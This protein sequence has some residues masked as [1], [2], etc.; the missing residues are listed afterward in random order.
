MTMKPIKIFTEG[1]VEINDIKYCLDDVSQSQL[2]TYQSTCNENI[3]IIKNNRLDELKRIDGLGLS[4]DMDM[5]HTY[6]RD[7][8]FRIRHHSKRVQSIEEELESQK[9]FVQAERC[10]KV[11]VYIGLLC[12]EYE[13]GYNDFIVLGRDC[14]SFRHYYDVEASFPI[15]QP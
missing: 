5:N 14:D 9:I 6:S 15:T 12:I 4:T 8:Q 1:I 2:I 7:N 10:S 11:S 13:D 3:E